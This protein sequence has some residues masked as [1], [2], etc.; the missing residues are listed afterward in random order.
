[1]PLFF[2]IKSCIAWMSIKYVLM[3]M[4]K[5]PWASWWLSD[6]ESTCNAGDLQLARDGFISWSGRFPG[7]RNGNPLQYSCLENPM[8]GG[9]WH[10]WSHKNSDSTEQLKDNKSQL[11]FGTPHKSICK[12]DLV[13][14]VGVWGFLLEAKCEDFNSNIEGVEVAWASQVVL[15][16]TCQC[17]RPQRHRFDP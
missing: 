2:S 16:L 4:L 17:R 10:W 3:R 1:M 7:K 15:E 9:T 14:I 6:K 12:R 13:Y 5:S 8:D 11:S